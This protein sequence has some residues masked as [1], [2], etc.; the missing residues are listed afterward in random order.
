M[1]LMIKY[2]RRFLNLNFIKLG[3]VN[4]NLR[5]YAL[6]NI[7][8]DDKMLSKKCCNVGNFSYKHSFQNSSRNK[9]THNLIKRCAHKLCKSI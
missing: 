1:V 3:V 2:H 6:P 4:F 5:K 8:N 9:F 7:L